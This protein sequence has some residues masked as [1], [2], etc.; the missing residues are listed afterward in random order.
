MIGGP[1]TADETLCLTSCYFEQLGTSLHDNGVVITLKKL[2]T[3]RGDYCNGTSSDSLQLR[4]FFQMG[5][6]L[7]GKNLLPEGANSFLSE[8]FLLV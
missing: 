2:R 5:T 3:S 7:K 8:D 1:I 6:S 4:P